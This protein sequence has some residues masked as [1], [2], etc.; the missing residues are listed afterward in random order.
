M[1]AGWHIRLCLLV[2]LLFSSSFLFAQRNAEKGDRYF[3][4]NLFTEAIKYYQQE[5][6]AGRSRDHVQYSKKQ[7]A[8]CYRISGEFEK[9]E[10]AYAK[11]LKR[12]KEQEDPD[13][14]LKYG[15]ALKSSAKYAEAKEQFKIFIEKAPDDPI[16]PVYLQSCDSAQ[17]WL[18]ETIGMEA[19]NITAINGAST[20]MAPVMLRNGQV[21][22]SSSRKGSKKAFISLEGGI[23]VDRLDLYAVDMYLLNGDSA[24]KLQHLDGINSPL[25]EGSA[26][27]SA[28]GNE[29][30]F[31]RT[32]KG[33]KDYRNKVVNV[34]QIYYSKK[35]SLGNWSE[36]VSAFPFNSYKYSVGQPSLSADGKIIFFMS[37]RKGGKGKTDIY[38]AERMEDGSWG[39]MESAGD[40]VNTFGHELFPYIS[41]GGTLYFSSDSHPGM[42]QLDIF[43]AEKNKAGNWAMVKNLKPP[44]N[45]IGDDFGI[46]FDGDAPR[47]M[48]TSDRFG[49]TGGEDIYSYGL[50][51]PLTLTINGGKV[52]FRD[53]KMFDG[54]KYKL[55][56]ADGNET[57]LTSEKGLF[58]LNLENGKAYTLIAKKGFFPYNKV[59]IKMN[60][61]VNGNALQLEVM[62]TGKNIRFDGY[63][64]QDVPDATPQPMV[65][66]SVS[67]KRGEAVQESVK[68]G[69]GGYFKFGEQLDPTMK[70]IISLD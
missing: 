24:G 12:K 57:T 17:A 69:Q 53:Y 60:R 45:S 25:H 8:E 42:G 61:G 48:W 31:T 37:D 62:S 32:V 11:I 68:S 54:L 14:Y 4:K 22:F 6:N 3:D 65:G 70:Y 51:A 36:P 52:Q 44:F 64:L 40:E 43:S 1:K 55:S 21:I 28:D 7:I 38:Y 58:E 26:T 49:G 23:Q 46:V 33:E 19:T 16:G 5:I 41:D 66:K 27:F 15:L 47:M 67:L 50:E 29:I 39:P 9:A 30:Y 34:L 18:D 10:K 2:G 35:D 63:L 56:D 13:N 59:E 20:D